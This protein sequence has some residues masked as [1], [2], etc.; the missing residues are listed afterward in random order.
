MAVS[1]LGADCLDAN[2]LIVVDFPDLRPQG[3]SSPNHSH[4]SSLRQGELELL[5]QLLT[6]SQACPASTQQV[7][8]DGP[9]PWALTGA[10]SGGQQDGVEAALAPQAVGEG[11]V[12]P[13]S[14]SLTSALNMRFQSECC[15]HLLPVDP[16][17]RN[18]HGKRTLTGCSYEF[19]RLADKIVILALLTLPQKARAPL[20]GE[21]WAVL[22][23]QAHTQNLVL[24]VPSPSSP[25]PLPCHTLRIPHRVPSVPQSTVLMGLS[26]KPDPL[27]K[28]DPSFY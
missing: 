20:L 27:S 3:L 2:F 5:G 23:S 9:Q 18:S 22:S 15:V 7:S 25:F 8:K 6:W 13:H 19:F 17:K 24:A 26:W 11:F 28:P 21:A 10:R 16:L 14:R 1:L 4:V 12:L